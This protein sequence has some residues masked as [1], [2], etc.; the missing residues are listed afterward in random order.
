M[1]NNFWLKILISIL[2]GIFLSFSAP[3]Y[4]LWIIAWIG[5]VPLFTIINISKRTS[6][7]LLL[8]FLF[9][10]S[11]NFS[12]LHWLLSLHPLT[13]LGL[14]IKESYFVSF[15]ALLIPAFYNALFFVLF[16]YVVILFKR[17]SSYKNGILNLL[18]ISIIWLIVFNKLSASAFLHGFP[19]TLIEY[20]QYKNLLLIQV[21][22]YFGS[23]SI[24]FLIVFFNL[25]L[26]NLLTSK[27]NIEKIGGRYI[28]SK[29]MPL[30]E[31]VYPFSLSLILIFSSVVYGVISYNLNRQKVS[32]NSKSVILL[33]GNLPIRATRGRNLDFDLAKNVYNRLIKGNYADLLVAPEGALPVLFDD[34]SIA[35]YW[36]KNIVNNKK[37]DV[38]F[39][40]YC[41]EGNP[42]YTNCAVLAKK[43]SLSYYDKERLVPFG[44]YVPFY[45][46][47]PGPLKKFSDFA[48][49]S[50]FKKGKRNSPLEL[51]N[52]KMDQKIGQ[53]I[54]INICFE[55]IFP[56]LIR[57]H[58]L[59]G[60][61][62][63]LNLSDLSWFRN[64]LIKKQFLAFGVFRAIENRKPLIISTNNGI[65]AF[66]EQNGKIKKCSNPD[67]EMILSDWINLNNKITFYAKYGW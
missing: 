41:N 40:T 6:E 37:T 26:S 43:E 67:E 35:K 14:S 47:L 23:V 5:L 32:Y 30:G 22:E 36:L 19:W 1:F 42:D 7:T 60:A 44:E 4:N 8:S 31:F 66:I 45:S 39:G 53:R 12:C 11:Y 10:F 62:F 54:G 27:L 20:S 57:K 33:Q 48:V 9:G 13:W 38:I 2:G 52:S 51:S 34:N 15:F 56:T 17:L 24:S 58:S 3:G 63:L 21:A 49:G 28:S 65:S 25:S 18:F 29:P 64:N 46:F 50:G 59:N 61:N 16:A 55:L